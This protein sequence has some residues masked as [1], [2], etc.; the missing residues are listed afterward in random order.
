[1]RAFLLVCLIVLAGCSQPPVDP[2]QNDLVA[3][4][5]LDKWWKSYTFVPPPQKPGTVTPA[6]IIT[7]KTGRVIKVRQHV[8][9]KAEFDEQT[10]DARY[11]ESKQA[12]IRGFSVKDKTVR[13]LTSLSSG[14][15]SISDHDGVSTSDAQSL[16]QDLGNFVFGK[17]TDQFGL[18]NIEI[19]GAQGEVLSS[20]KGIRAACVR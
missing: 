11:M 17:P 5:A 2:N 12:L 19:D 7:M 18:E 1:M 14:S 13:A 6:H 20:R 16:C 3:K 9:T 15:V 4:D 10:T 8:Q